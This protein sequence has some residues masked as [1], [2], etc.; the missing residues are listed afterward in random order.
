M[1]NLFT[2]HQPNLIQQSQ[3]PHSQNHRNSVFNV[4]NRKSL[5]KGKCRFSYLFFHPDLRAHE[6]ISPAF[7]QMAKPR[8]AICHLLECRV[9]HFVGIA[10]KCLKDDDPMDNIGYI[11]NDSLIFA[12]ARN[13]PDC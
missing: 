10:G 4:Q 12:T 1:G 13:Y 5:E 11:E 2:T 8:Q 9:N 7:K 6:I 3:Q